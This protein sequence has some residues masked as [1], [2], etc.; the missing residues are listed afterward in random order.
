MHCKRYRRV[1]DTTQ[2]PVS[3]QQSPELLNR[4]MSTSDYFSESLNRAV[5]DDSVEDITGKPSPLLDFGKKEREYICKVIQI[6]CQ[7]TNLLKKNKFS[8]SNH[9]DK[10][11][12]TLGK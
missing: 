11:L 7:R 10:K 8:T 3:R 4:A 5:Q 1:E 12:S 9:A 2:A 6:A